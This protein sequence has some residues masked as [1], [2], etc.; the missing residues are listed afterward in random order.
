MKFT[1]PACKQLIH[2]VVSF[3]VKPITCQPAFFVL[4]YVLLGAP[5][6]YS[7]LVLHS[8]LPV[9]KAS[10]A[11]L[12]CY[13]LALPVVFLPVRSR[14]FYKTAL[15]VF[16]GFFFLVDVYLLLLYNETFGTITKDAI[17]AVLATNPEESVEYISTYFT[18]DKLLI[19]SAI[20]S[21]VFTLFK[22]LRKLHFRWN[23]IARCAVLILLF[24]SAFKS[25][26]QIE[27][28][29]E[30]NLYYL[31]TKECPDLRE[32]RQNP[33][34]S[35][36]N[37]SVDNIVLLVGESFSKFHSSLYGYEKETNPRLEKLRQDKALF[38]CENIT[39]ACVTTIPSMKSIMMSYIDSMCDSIEW[40]RCLT[41]IEVMQKAGY[42]TY[43]LSNQSKRGFFDNEVGAYSDL[44]DRQF[45]LGEKYVFAGERENT[46]SYLDENLINVLDSFMRESVG[47]RMY[48][49]H[50]MG[51][52]AGYNQR[53]PSD[54]SKFKEA[55]YI[56]SHLSSDKR[57]LLAEYDNS[58]LYND[59]VVYELL[60]LFDKEDAIVVYLSDHGEDVFR[61]SDKICT[62]AAEFDEQH[63]LVVKQIP[64]MFYTS[65]LFREK[66][67]E[68]QQR[69]EGAINRP[70]RTDSIMYT[71][72]DIAGVETVNGISYKHKS[73]FK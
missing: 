2:K 3:C 34:I 66:H 6:I 53:Y 5:D 29:K 48:I 24:F 30:F 36:R 46:K 20:L 13:I 42:R 72:M 22:Y 52:H 19:I 51:S 44:C 47:K 64:M 12:S 56:D 10:F 63:K 40:H 49:L 55:D 57:I 62:H 60:R 45:F 41:L 26:R 32:Y 69:I 23:N 61:S 27:K 39:S 50:L 54:F 15:L 16:A 65:Q 43:W 59:S 68:L 14:I 37:E 38:V 28:V 11:F 7:I 4:L 21:L 1:P 9:F 73:L 58:V 33:S 31:I 35:C 71:I 70:Y 25:L 17:A 67:P 8:L 18:I